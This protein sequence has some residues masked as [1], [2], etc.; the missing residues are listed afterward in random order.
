FS[1][2]DEAR[3]QAGVLAA[4][5]AALAGDAT[6]ARTRLRDCFELLLES[7]ERFYPVD[8]FLVDL[9]LLTAQTADEDW[10]RAIASRDV[11]NYLVTAQDLEEIAQIRQE[12][13]QQLAQLWREGRQEC[14]GGA[15]REVPVPLLPLD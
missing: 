4:A 7:R 11:I 13:L 5:K 14:V 15:Y 9:C 12:A 1:E 8:C 3:M 2:L 10:L 6:A